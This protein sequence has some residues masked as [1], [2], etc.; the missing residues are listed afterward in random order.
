MKIVNFRIVFNE[1]YGEEFRLMGYQPFKRRVRER[2]R[3]NVA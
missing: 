3:E 2:E 1:D